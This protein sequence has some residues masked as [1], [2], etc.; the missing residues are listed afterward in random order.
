MGAQKINDLA[1]KTGTYTKNGETKGRYENIGS[2]MESDDGSQFILLK[3]TFNPAG[4]PCDPD[5][6]QI[7]ISVF[8]LR[9]DAPQRQQAPARDP[10]PRR[11][12]PAGNYGAPRDAGQKPR[13][14]D[15][16]PDDDIP[17]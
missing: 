4:V 6:D 11:E 2:L 8:E 9:E 5:R 1:V 16:F 3:R 10:A 14:D 15:P 7:L 17:F 13:N 12:Q